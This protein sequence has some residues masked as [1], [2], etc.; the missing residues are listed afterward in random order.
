MTQ[1]WVEGAIWPWVVLCGH[2]L[3]VVLV[4]GIWQSDDL[5][6]IHKAYVSFLWVMWMF[7][8]MERATREKG[9]SHGTR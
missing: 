8:I 5:G 2:L 6:L 9:G 3:C 1:A 7:I 4:A